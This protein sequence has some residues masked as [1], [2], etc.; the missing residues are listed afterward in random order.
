[1][2]VDG[3]SPA[4]AWGSGGR[5]RVLGSVLSDEMRSPRASNLLEAPGA[6]C[7]DG[8]QMGGWGAGLCRGVSCSSRHFL[9]GG[10]RTE[11][12]ERRLSALPGPAQAN[13]LLQN[14]TS[15][16][17]GEA[18]R[19]SQRNLCGSRAG[20]TRGKGTEALEKEVALQ[21]RVAPGDGGELGWAGWAWKQGKAR[22]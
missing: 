4:G 12:G 14:Q 10:E 13:P 9:L 3:K 21:V 8:W 1:M 19:Q 6:G 15:I 2:A 22:G 20:Q 7:W 17:F 5:T 11:D 18:L 16:S